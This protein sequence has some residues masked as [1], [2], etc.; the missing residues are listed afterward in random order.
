MLKNLREKN[1]LSE[2]KIQK[3]ELFLIALSF[4]SISIYMIYHYYKFGF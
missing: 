2:K 3:I 4:F 1:K